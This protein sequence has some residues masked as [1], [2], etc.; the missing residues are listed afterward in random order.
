MF[1]EQS[2]VCLN[3]N[4]VHTLVAPSNAIA[5]SFSTGCKLSAFI[6]MLLMATCA[7]YQLCVYS[8]V[9]SMCVVSRNKYE[10]HEIG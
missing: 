4:E 7:C 1:V 3:L 10:L 2:G 9:S 6:S 5:T 8:S